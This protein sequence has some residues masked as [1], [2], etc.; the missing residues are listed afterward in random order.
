M[1]IFFKSF[2]CH[3]WKKYRFLL[4]GISLL[5]LWKRDMIQVDKHFC[6]RFWFWQRL[7]STQLSVPPIALYLHGAASLFCGL[8]RKQIKEQ[9]WHSHSGWTCLYCQKTKQN[10]K[11]CYNLRAIIAFGSIANYSVLGS[12]LCSWAS[13]PDYFC[14]TFPALLWQGLCAIALLGCIPG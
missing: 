9:R 10:R 4:Y 6:K 14:P 7:W 12:P 3:L 11:G 1:W 2:K 8:Q 13:C 5:F